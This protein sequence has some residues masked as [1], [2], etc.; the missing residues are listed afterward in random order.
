[1]L[2]ARAQYLCISY[3]LPPTFFVTLQKGMSPVKQVLEENHVQPAAPSSSTT[4]VPA[5]FATYKQETDGK[6]SEQQRINK[7]Q[8]E[9]IKQQGEEITQQCEE[10]K[11]LSRTVRG[12]E[13]IEVRKLKDSGRSIILAVLKMQQMPHHWNTFV[14]NLSPKQESMLRAN[15]ISHQAV[16]ATLYDH[17]QQQ[18]NEAAHDPVAKVIANVV[19]ALPQADKARF[20][21]LFDVVFGGGVYESIVQGW[22]KQAA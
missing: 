16:L 3:V 9:Q 13:D 5:W 18:G 21:E 20:V 19:M 4:D 11:S 2:A 6:F 12:Y 17:Y 1:M 10:I 7:K 22:T 15:K 8:S 14:V